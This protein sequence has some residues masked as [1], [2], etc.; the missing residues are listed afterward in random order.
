MAPFLI[1]KVGGALPE[2]AATLG[3][4]EEWFRN[5]LGIPEARVVD[6][7]DG[8]ALPEAETLGGVLIT[9]SAS[10]VTARAP[11]SV[12]TAEWIPSVL[13]AEVPL[14]GVCY[15]HQLIADALGGTVAPN[16]RG[17]QIG[18]IEVT[19]CSSDDPLLS[20]VPEVFQV[21]A[22]HVESVVELP[23]GVASAATSPR[24]DHHAFRVGERAWGVQ[25]HP[26][27]DASI[28]RSCIR[29]RAEELRAEGIDPEEA[30]AAATDTDHGRTL[31]R[32]FA[33]L[34]GFA[35]A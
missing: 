3:D 2:V 25:F 4:F 20:S 18:T 17:R 14:L 12:R 16:P 34:A 35:R 15:G 11:W 10:M 32:R 28:I 21:Q 26:E 23:P 8:S 22:T 27:M 7:R 19:T 24:D 6:V 13:A 33:E 29:V 5:G 31:L 1:V 9:G 30:A